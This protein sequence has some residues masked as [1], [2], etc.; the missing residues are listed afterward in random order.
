MQ[1]GRCIA[2]LYGEDACFSEAWEEDNS[3]E[4]EGNAGE[5]VRDWIHV[6]HCQASEGQRGCHLPQR[7]KGWGYQNKDHH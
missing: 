6:A 2:R 5:K 7:E 1:E 4:N 3:N